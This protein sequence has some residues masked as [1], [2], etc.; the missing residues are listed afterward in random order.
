MVSYE[1]SLPEDFDDY[2]WEVESKGWFN[3]AV[4]TYQ[5]KQYKLN[6]YDP[7]RLA[8]EIADELS[9]HNVFLEDNMLVLRK[10]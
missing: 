6:F 2:E 10:V 9:D 7:T 3:G 8:Q 5:H 1:L 4:L